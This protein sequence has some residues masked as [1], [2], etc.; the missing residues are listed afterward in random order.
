MMITEKHAPTTSAGNS[1]GV[2]GNMQ[3]LL[4]SLGSRGRVEVSGPIVQYIRDC[5][6][7]Q[8]SLLN[9]WQRRFSA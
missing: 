5:S 7:V 8:G 3:E 1:Y 9:A 4:G 2:L 6:E